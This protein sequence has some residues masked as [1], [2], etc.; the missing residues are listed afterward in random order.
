MSATADLQLNPTTS[1]ARRRSDRDGDRRAAR[2]RLVSMLL[3]AALLHGLV[4]LGVTFG[5]LQDSAGGAKG[6]EVLLVSNELPEARKNDGATY[7]S[8][9]T[10]AGSGNTQE[11]TAARVPG[12][13]PPGGGPKSAPAPD[14]AEEATE[15][16]L[17]TTTATRARVS[18]TAMPLK[19]ALALRDIELPLLLGDSDAPPQPQSLD[20]DRDLALR[21]PK[22]DELYVT[23]DTRASNLAPY[24]DGWRRRVERIGTLNYPSVAQRR[25]LTGNPV[26]EVTIL[27]TGQL[28]SAV[29]RRSSGYPEIDAA[30]LD[31]LKLASP[32]E[33]FPQSLSSQYRVLHFAYEWQFVGGR[34][35]GGAVAVP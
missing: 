32:F 29:I 1:P 5:P 30:T 13:A 33:P 17:L 26:V 9:R 6:L 10:Q 21:G 24:L 14:S 34:L 28:E 20:A 8:Q 23:A 7:L 25:K 16:E 4:L 3:L 27:R 22:R 2:D 18:F 19:E 12:T 11:R 31:I 35:G 15:D